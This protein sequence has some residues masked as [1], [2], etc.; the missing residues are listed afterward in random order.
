MDNLGKIVPEYIKKL[1][2]RSSE[3]KVYQSH[4]WVGLQLSSLLEDPSHK[5]L[6]MKLAK[7]HNTNDL[8]G[9]AKRIS[10]NDNIRNKGA[11]FMKVFYGKK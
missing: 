3:S 4:Q 10:Q 1:N 5:A 9:L 2:E 8:M 11:Y 7:N 6:Y